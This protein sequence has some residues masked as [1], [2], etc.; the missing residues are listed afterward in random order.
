MRCE[1]C[2]FYYFNLRIL[3]IGIICKKFKLPIEAAKYKGI[4]KCFES[5]LKPNP[6]ARSKVRTIQAHPWP[7]I[8]RP[9]GPIT[10]SSYDS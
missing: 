5:R 2:Q 9:C 3:K 6:K 7:G 4:R 1:K 8:Y 10:R